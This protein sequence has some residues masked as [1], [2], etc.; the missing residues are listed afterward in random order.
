MYIVDD[1][2]RFIKVIN[3]LIGTV[4]IMFVNKVLPSFIP[5]MFANYNMRAL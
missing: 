5:C 3:K 2:F 1:A 4:Q